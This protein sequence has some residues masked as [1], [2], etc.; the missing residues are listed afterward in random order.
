MVR[1]FH[2]SF[3]LPAAAA[4]LRSLPPDLAGQR[5]ALLEE[6]FQEYVAATAAGDPVAVADALADIVYVC[7]GTAL[8]FGVDLDA[9]MAAV[10]RSNMAKAGA[11]GPLVD[12]RGK[13]VKPA[14][15]RPPDVAGAAGLAA[16]AAPTGT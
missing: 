3:G 6:E 2:R 5:L 1:Q 13:V 12:R 16:P 15:W 8:A 10:H 9:V 14:G 7:Y 4:P 11:A